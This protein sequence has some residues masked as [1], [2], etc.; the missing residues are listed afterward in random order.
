MTQIAIADRA[1][2]LFGASSTPG[3]EGKW[4]WPRTGVPGTALCRDDNPTPRHDPHNADAG[5]P[6]NPTSGSECGRR[7]PASAMRSALPARRPELMKRASAV[8]R[9][10][11]QRDGSGAR[12]LFAAKREPGTEPACSEGEWPP[13]QPFTTRRNAP[14]PRQKERSKY[15]AT[16]PRP[17]AV[18]RFALPLHVPRRYTQIR[19]PNEA[20]T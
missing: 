11:R 20:M 12:H 2:S 13:G 15:P 16:T 7:P 4:G 18:P 3:V 8:G 6:G 1:S 17:L 9:P 14:S 10:S 19:H 5:L